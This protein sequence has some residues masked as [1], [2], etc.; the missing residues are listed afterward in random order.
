MH[1]LLVSTYELGH[2][3]LHLASPASAI[4]LAGHTVATSDVAVEPFRSRRLDGVD[5]VAI[6]VPMHTAMR[7]AADLVERIRRERPAIPIALFGL[8][9]SMNRD[10]DVDAMFVGEYE[11]DLV[12]WLDSGGGRS[13]VRLNLRPGRFEVPDR[14]TLPPLSQYAHLSVGEDHRQ[15][16]YLEASHG[17]RHRCRHCP[18]PAI[19]D[20][21]YRVVGEEVVVQDAVQQV[22]AGARHLTIG[23]PDFLN[24]PAHAMS[25]LRALHARLPDITYDVTIKVEHLLA[26]RE[27]LPELAGL[28][29]LYVVS[30]FESVDDRTLALLEKGHTV[31]DMREA[32]ALANQAGLDLHPSWMPFVPW[33]TPADVVGIFRF[34]DDHD[35]MSVTDPVQMAIRLLIPPG[36]LMLELPEI[37][38]SIGSF[39]PGAL[40]YPWESLD[41]RV[42]ELQRKMA[43]LAERSASIGADPVE[44]LVEQ[45]ATALEAAGA[46]IAEAQIPAG[47]TSGRPRMTE[48]WFC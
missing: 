3:P 35:L 17:C 2:Q 6:S 27:L 16:G 36:S 5:A 32:V 7:L 11:P 23:D 47:A 29:V 22:D 28:G 31:A 33:T 46:D 37:Q 34:L 43:Q 1:V 15:V 8:Y 26:H 41:P 21:R 48:P 40:T 19:Y 13:G 10:L 25:V 39:D 9:A 30:A 42:D 44:T 4:Q 38:R 18:I 24:G 45:W 12:R 20:G 14:S